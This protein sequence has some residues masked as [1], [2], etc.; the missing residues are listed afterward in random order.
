[1]PGDH[2]IVQ[3][4]PASGTIP[5]LEPRLH[6]QLPQPREASAGSEIDDLHRR[7]PDGSLPLDG[8][9]IG[10][11]SSEGDNARFVGAEV[12]WIHPAA[13]DP[14]GEQI[15][16]VARRDAV[17]L[18]SGRGKVNGEG[19]CVGLRAWDEGEVGAIAYNFPGGMEG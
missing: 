15:E 3:R 11:G 18:G 8:G 2:D 6:V 16:R 17:E 10:L 4:N 1:M 12:L 14:Q 5:K 13:D 9:A 7:L 19:N